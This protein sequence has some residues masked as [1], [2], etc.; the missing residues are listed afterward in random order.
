MVKCNVGAGFNTTRGRGTTNRGWCMRDYTRS[1]MFAGAI[2][3]FGHYPIL[4]AEALAL[5][6]AIHSAIEMQLENV[7]FESDSQ[8]TVHAIHTNHNGFSEFNFIIS[9]IHS[10]LHNF[11]NFE[12]KFV[13]R[14]ANA[15]AHFIAKAADSWSRRSLF[16]MIPLCIEHLLLND[17]S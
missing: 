12:V 11:P 5:K 8:R 15:V 14:Q 2:W 17:M 13:K 9:F 7:I 3:D 6:E 1:F 10:L 4:E 16:H